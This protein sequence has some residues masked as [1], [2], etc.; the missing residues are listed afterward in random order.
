MLNPV[1][2]H[3][4]TKCRLRAGTGLNFL[5]SEVSKKRQSPFHPRK[6]HRSVERKISTQLQ[7]ILSVLKKKNQVLQKSL[8]TGPSF[9]YLFI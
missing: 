7:M 8:V 6:A 5:D 9:I 3:I 2:P 4:F 1:T